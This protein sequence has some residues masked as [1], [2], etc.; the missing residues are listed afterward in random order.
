MINL[1]EI[2]RILALWSLEGIRHYDKEKYLGW[3]SNP[4][5]RK[6]WILNPARLP[7]SPPRQRFQKYKKK[8]FTFNLNLNDKVKNISK[9][10]IQI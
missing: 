3:E 7:I 2:T 8:I 10:A 4:H 1:A 5:S 6:N 9:F